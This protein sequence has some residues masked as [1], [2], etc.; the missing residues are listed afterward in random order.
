MLVMTK[1]TNDWNTPSYMDRQ[2][3]PSLEV[4]SAEHV[5]VQDSNHTLS[6]LIQD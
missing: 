1:G 3:L 6:E 4:P 5:I 2:N